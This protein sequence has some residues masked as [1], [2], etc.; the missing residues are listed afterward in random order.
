MN[1]FKDL[2]KQ[3]DAFLLIIQGSM[4][5]Q[6]KLNA[7]ISKSFVSNFQLLYEITDVIYNLEAEDDED[8]LYDAMLSVEQDIISNYEE[9]LLIS[10]SGDEPDS[11]WVES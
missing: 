4:P 10:Q 7:L 2:V 1:V 5:A 8:V 3:A 6:M 11:E 9:W